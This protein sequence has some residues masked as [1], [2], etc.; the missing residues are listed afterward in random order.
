MDDLVIIGNI[1]QFVCS[2]IDQLNWK[3]SLKDMNTL[4][5]FLGVEVLPTQ[6]NIFFV[7]A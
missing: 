4:H 6:D 1:S 7:L 2:I 3:F 5:Y